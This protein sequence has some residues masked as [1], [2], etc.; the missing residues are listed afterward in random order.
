MTK[1]QLSISSGLALLLGGCSTFGQD[2]SVPDQAKLNLPDQYYAKGSL[3]TTS[4]DDIISWWTRLDDPLLDKIVAKSIVGNLDM[5][6]A[7]AR[8]RQAREL[9]IQARA[10]AL[11]SLSASGTASQSINSDA[12]DQTNIS[13]GMDASYEVDIFGGVSASIAAARADRQAAA[14]DL[15]AVQVSLVGD[16]ARY[17]T[18]ARSA[19]QRLVLA[20]ETL[21]YANNNLQIAQWRRQA[22][23]VSSLDVEQARG[24]RA[25]AAANIPLYRSDYLTAAYRLGVLTGQAPA[26]LVKDMDTVKAIPDVPSS[27]AIGIPANTMRQ[28]PD[29][30]SAERTLAASVY[31]IGVERADLYPS[32]SIGGDFG[33]NILS[34]GGIADTLTNTIFASLN[35]LIFDG[36]RA[37]SEVRGQEQEAEAAF[38]SYQQTI[39][40]SLEEVENA[41]VALETARER[42][43]AFTEALDAARNQAI[44][45]RMSYRSGLNDFAAVLDAETALVT[46]NDGLISSRA[47]SALA[48]IQLYRSLG[49]GWEPTN[50]VQE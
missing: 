11:P 26:A 28:R 44:L 38:A 2:Y 49:G 4:D 40:L 32:L 42:E 39:L 46:A 41:L 17:Y 34:I 43:A 16:V 22:G 20:Q 21:G 23:L 10:G 30:R 29:V 47:A 3:A 8:L 9:E 5:K 19:Q 36:G 1:A 18:D 15:S 50:D 31:R 14:Y 48:F 45:A 6:V 27:I 24:Q 12:G 37:K 35:Q 13:L 33:T 25:Q 7:V